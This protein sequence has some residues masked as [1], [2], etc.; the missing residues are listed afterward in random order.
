M[1]FVS[2]KHAQ[3]LLMARPPGTFLLRFSDATLGGISIVYNSIDPGK[4]FLRVAP[5]LVGIVSTR[6]HSEENDLESS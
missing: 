4:L 2:K 6:N 5:L 1:G 3:D